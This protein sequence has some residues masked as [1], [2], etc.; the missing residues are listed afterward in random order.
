M[1]QVAL[2][3]AYFVY[4][5]TWKK[6]PEKSVGKKC[7]LKFESKLNWNDVSNLLRNF[8]KLNWVNMWPKNKFKSNH[9]GIM[10]LDSNIESKS[11]NNTYL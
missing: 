11:S 9:T 5:A 4:I 1:C 3:N 8:K 2:I 6:V 7:Q 10:S